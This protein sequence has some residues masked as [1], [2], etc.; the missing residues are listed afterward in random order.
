MTWGPIVV[1]V[2]ASAASAGA[3]A[4]GWQLAQATGA[5]C[6]LVHAARE[7]WVGAG[8]A[9]GMVDVGAL[10]ADVIRLSRE[11]VERSLAGKVPAELLAAME[12]RSGSPSQ[13]L[14]DI[15]AERGAELVVLGAKR[16]GLV[17][18]WLGGST[19]KNAIRALDVSV[20][21]STGPRPFSRILVPVDLSDAAL[22]TLKTAERF[23]TLFGAYLRVMHVIE[24]FPYAAEGITVVDVSVLADQ[25]EEAFEKTIWSK[26]TTAGAEKVVRRG[27][28]V[29]AIEDE[30]I[31]WPADLVVVGAH[32]R[33]RVERIFLGSVSEGVVNALPSSVL[34]VRGAG[35]GAGS[36]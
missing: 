9:P 22:P 30:A 13:I 32:G 10:V 36:R 35:P 18:R 11:E 2:D 21:V 8:G 3:A 28:A 25:A 29:A 20:L 31:E 23:A 12:V 26:V 33:G 34:V 24:P 15:V 19:A 5:P 6:Q 1:G 17:A 14:R 27:P 7:I 4:T 16:H